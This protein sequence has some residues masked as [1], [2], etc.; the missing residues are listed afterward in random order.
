MFNNFKGG[1]EQ[2]TMSSSVSYPCRWRTRPR[3]ALDCLG[4][5]PLEC[6]RV[7]PLPSLLGTRGSYV[8]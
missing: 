6:Y 8:I 7:C 1:V 4:L 3:I 2:D 5:G